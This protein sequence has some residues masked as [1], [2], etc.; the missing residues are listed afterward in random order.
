M[1]RGHSNDNEVADE[2][3]TSCVSVV[4]ITDLLIG[5]FELAAVKFRIDTKFLPG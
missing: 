2:R 5:Y 1:N 4:E 3:P